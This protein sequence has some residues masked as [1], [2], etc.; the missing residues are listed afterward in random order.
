[1]TNLFIYSVIIL[2]LY[3]TNSLCSIYNFIF[4]SFVSST[5]S[6]TSFFVSFTLSTVSKTFF[7]YCIYVDNYFM[8]R[9]LSI[10]STPSAALSFTL[11]ITSPILSRIFYIIYCIFNYISYRFYCIF[12][13]FYYIF[14]VSITSVIFSFLFIYII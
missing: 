10:S 14:T 7:F 2:I 11:F 1:M 9:H 4:L 12:Y 5:V 3:F 13:I 8:I 6:I